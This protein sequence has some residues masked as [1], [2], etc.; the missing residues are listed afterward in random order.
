MH[1]FRI[2]AKCS[3]F[4]LKQIEELFE[5]FAPKVKFVYDIKIQIKDIM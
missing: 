2:S 1:D 3:N 5:N 4:G